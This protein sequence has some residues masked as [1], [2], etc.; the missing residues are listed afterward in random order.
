MSLPSLFS[1]FSRF[2]HSP[3]FRDLACHADA[4]HSILKPLL[5]ALLLGAGIGTHL[6][7]TLQ[8]IAGRTYSHRLGIAKPKPRVMRP[9]PHKSMTQKPC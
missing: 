4:A 1:A 6:L 7:Q 3:Q 9:N 2:L 5:P 8:L